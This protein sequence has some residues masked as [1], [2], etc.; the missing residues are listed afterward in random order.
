MFAG[1]FRWLREWIADQLAPSEVRVE[2]RALAR[3][4]LKLGTTGF[5]GGIAVISQIRRLVVHQRKWMT[6]EEFLDAVSLAQS[7]PGANAANATTYVGLRLGG[8]RGAAVSVVS[9]ILPSFLMMIGLTIAHS[10]LYKFPDAQRIFQGFNAAVVGLI[11]ATVTRLGKTAMQQQWHLEL[12]VA[13]GFMLIFT[14]TTIAE[15]VLLAG[16]IGIFIQFYKTRARQQI[17]QKISKERQA[18]VREVALEQQARQ[19][20]ADL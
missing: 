13:A 8:V 3:T 6:E 19:H 2:W 10:Y 4:F 1:S 11:A 14:A 16:M 15:V 7:L 17:R 20:A 9:F 5:G 18:T 12:G